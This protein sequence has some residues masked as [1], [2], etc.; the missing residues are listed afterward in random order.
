MLTY[1]LVLAVVVIVLYGSFR[2]L[3]GGAEVAADDYR[4]VLARLCEFTGNRADEL[5]TALASSPPGPAASAG[6]APTDPLAETAK[7]ARKS[8]GGYHQQLGRLESD[9]S[10]EDRERLESARALLTAAVEDLAWACR[11]VEAGTLRDNPGMAGAVEALRSH[12]EQ[13][14]L[15]AAPLVESPV[16]VDTPD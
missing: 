1:L 11:L 3:G 2:A 14:L 8:L 4:T 9:A 10:G 12:G 5:R 13:C 6:R 16:R 15:A 7:S